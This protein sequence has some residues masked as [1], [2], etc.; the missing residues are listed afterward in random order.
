VD[1]IEDLQSGDI[2][3]LS[4]IDAN[5][6]VA[7]N[8]AFTF[9]GDAAFSNVAGELRATANLVQGDVN[10]DGIADFQINLTQLETAPGAGF[11]DL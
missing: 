7:G 5:Q 2:I 3:D 11:F 10:G 9:V 1:R 4:D 8:Q 6:N